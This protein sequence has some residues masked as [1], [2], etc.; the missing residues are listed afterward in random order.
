[1][2][3]DKNILDAP[4]TAP[5][6]SQK[7]ESDYTAANSLDFGVN[8]FLMGMAGL[9]AAGILIHRG[10]FLYLL[11]WNLI[12]GS[13][14]LLSALVG[15]VRG[16]RKKLYYLVA[17]IAYLLMFFSLVTVFDSS[18]TGTNE[19]IFFGVFIILL[20]L[21]GATYYTFL[22]WEAKNQNS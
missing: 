19:Q 10:A 5:Q 20:P 6:Q 22:C 9:F 8:V 15:A 18:I 7:N 2:T 1:M 14:Q 21:I 4:L 12:L 13:Y 17:A 11:L 16:N 3:N